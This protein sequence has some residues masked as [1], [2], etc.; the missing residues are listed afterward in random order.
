VGFRGCGNPLPAVILRS[1]RRSRVKRRKD[2]CSS[3]KPQLPGFF[4]LRPK[5]FRRR[6][7]SLRMTESKRFSAA[8][9]AAGQ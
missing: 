2:L 3:L 4:V 6:V 1:R 9:F 5:A 7:A 8:S